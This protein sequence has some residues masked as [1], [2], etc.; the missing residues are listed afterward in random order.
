MP[1]TINGTAG[2]TFNDSTTQGTAFNAT[3]VLNATAGASAGAVGTYARAYLLP[4]VGVASFGN[5]FAGSNL[6]VAQYTWQ[7]GYNTYFNST[8]IALSGTWRY[9]GGGDTETLRSSSQAVFLRI[10]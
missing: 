6:R 1:V 4:N 5:T 9:L 7:A 2:V 3:A 10:S 8:Q